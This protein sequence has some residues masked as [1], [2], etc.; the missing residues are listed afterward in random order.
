MSST[1]L[2]FLGLQ[3]ETIQIHDF[4][5]CGNKIV[6]EFI[7][8]TGLAISFR[9]GA[10][11]AIRSAFGRRF[12]AGRQSPTLTPQVGSLQPA[13]QRLRERVLPQI[14]GMST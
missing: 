13:A 9:Y 12:A 10:Q 5:P 3:I 6:N 1:D 14:D 7:F 4:I 8:R 2:E 11:L